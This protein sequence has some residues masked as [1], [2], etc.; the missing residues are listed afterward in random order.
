M[1]RA[2]EVRAGGEAAA[3]ERGPQHCRALPHGPAAPTPAGPRG[4][5]DAAVSAGRSAQRG[6]A[7][8][9]LREGGRGGKELLFC[10]RNLFLI[11]HCLGKEQ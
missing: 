9:A 2:A 10:S 8:C 5:T 3:R 6:S 7:V 1:P 4:L 11:N